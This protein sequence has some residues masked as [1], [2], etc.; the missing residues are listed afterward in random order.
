MEVDSLNEAQQVEK[1]P[2]HFTFPSTPPPH[3]APLEVV[4]W[5]NEIRVLV[6]V[7]LLLL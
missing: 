3:V 2:K 5:F 6:F 7:G 1:A 4:E